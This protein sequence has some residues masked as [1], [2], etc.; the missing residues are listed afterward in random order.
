LPDVPARRLIVVAAPA[1][2]RIPPTPVVA[3][4]PDGFVRGETLMY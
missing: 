2:I 3:H 1:S 4:F